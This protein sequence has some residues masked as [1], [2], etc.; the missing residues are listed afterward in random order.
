MRLRCLLLAVTLLSA[1][2]GALAQP[3]PAQPA[4]APSEADRTEEAKGLFA[5]GRAAFDAGRYEDALDYFERSHAMSGRPALLYNIALA[6]DRLRNDEKALQG[7]EAYLAAVPDAPNRSDVETR[8]AAIRA[9]LARREPAPPS[10]EV[11]APAEVAAGAEPAAP[12]PATGAPE[13]AMRD[14][15]A[16]P[17]ESGSV[18]SKWWFWTAVGVVVAGGATAIVLAAS[19]EDDPKPLAPRSGVVVTTLRVAP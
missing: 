11:P 4:P 8:A 16:E 3:A 18:L 12:A 14:E 5:A 19:G 6:H 17:G 13:Q 9:A 7:Y 15:P 1:S 10:A 2:A